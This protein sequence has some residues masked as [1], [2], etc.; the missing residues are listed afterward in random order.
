LALADVITDFQNGLDKIK[1]EGGLTFGG[2][3]IGDDG[4][5]NAFIQIT[6][7]GEYL[8]VLTGVAPGALDAT[9]FI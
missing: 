6:A 2:L 9:D 1:L 4:S 8:A 7:S 5:G 3:T